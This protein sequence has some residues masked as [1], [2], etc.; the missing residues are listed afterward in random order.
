MSR[1]LSLHFRSGHDVGWLGGGRG[2]SAR[3]QSL[4]CLGLKC[5][6]RPGSPASKELFSSAHVA[7]HV[8]IHVVGVDALVALTLLS[9][10]VHL[11]VRTLLGL[12][13]PRLF[14]AALPPTV[15]E[16]LLVI[17]EIVGFPC[18]L[19]PIQVRRHW[20]CCRHCLGVRKA[21][22]RHGRHFSLR[23]LLLRLRHRSPRG[24]LRAGDG[25]AAPTA[26]RPGEVGPGVVRHEQRRGC[27]P[28]NW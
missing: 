13:T 23:A 5:L 10:F 18:R 17:V 28:C 22:V 16:L 25:G 1:G 15:E 21:Q 7:S 24:R 8:A 27:R 4:R 3:R 26:Q 14:V 9:S 20:W 12:H 19:E 6:I 11:V 2:A